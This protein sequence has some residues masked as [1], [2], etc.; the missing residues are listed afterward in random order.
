M[1]KNIK[2]FLKKILKFTVPLLLLPLSII[3]TD[4]F[5]YLDYEPKL[6]IDRIHTV[7][8]LNVAD[9]ALSEVLKINQN[10]KS[11]VNVVSIGDS[12][13]RVLMSGGFETRWEG[14]IYG[15]NHQ[16]YDLSFGGAQLDESLSLL[17]K[18]I[19]YLDSLKT[20]I[21]VLPVDRILTF[22]K[23]RNRIE[24]S[25]FDG[26]IPILKYL[27][28]FHQ[29]TYLFYSNS[30]KASLVKENAKQAN[31]ANSF[32]ENFNTTNIE[33]FNNNLSCI[34][35]EVNKLKMKYNVIIIIPPYK[36]DFFE[37]IMTQHKEDYDYYLNALNKEPVQ[38]INLQEYEN[39]FHFTDPVHGFIRN[40]NINELIKART[41]N[42]LYK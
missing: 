19:K 28:N 42:I 5:D 20:I 29:L 11:R 35:S 41:H 22:K 2:L 30:G 27:L 16:C 38:I 17:K 3:I 8:R 25:Q 34:M 36:K 32:M 21:I 13:G 24:N 23:H 39:D 18:E 1:D 9:W 31:I 10:T 26:K 33:A 37:K 6:N 40:G 4:P 15:P 7:R 14:R 12:R